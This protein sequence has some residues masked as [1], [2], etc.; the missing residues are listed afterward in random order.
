MAEYFAAET[1]ADPGYSGLL[2][3]NAGLARSD[4]RFVV[5]E[6]QR[7][8]PLLELADWVRA[9]FRAPHRRKLRSAAGRN[10]VLFDLVLREAGR[11]RATEEDLWALAW[12]TNSAFDWPLAPSEVRGIVESVCRYQAEW[13]ANGWH[14]DAFGKHQAAR[15]RLSGK[16]RARKAARAAQAAVEQRAGGCDRA[17]DHGRSRGVPSDCLQIPGPGCPA[18]Q[19][20][21]ER[22]NGC[23]G[24]VVAGNVVLTLE[25]RRGSWLHG[26]QDGMRSRRHGTGW[27]CPTRSRPT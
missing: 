12:E 16:A 25:G 23:G 2:F 24:D 6:R 7:Q 9:G 21:V 22:L 19:H 11:E 20:R 5:E 8:W 15:G 4:P 10:C 18:N 26:K 13:R 27:P 17:R 3:R 14:S 1:Q